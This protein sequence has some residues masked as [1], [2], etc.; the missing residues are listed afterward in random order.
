MASLR[1][2][3]SGAVSGALMGAELGSIIPGLG[4]LLGTGIGGLLGGLGAL[5]GRELPKGVMSGKDAR[6]LLGQGLTVDQI[7][8]LGPVG[9][10][11]PGKSMRQFEKM[12]ISQ[13]DAY[14][15]LASGGQGAGAGKLAKKFPQL[16]ATVGQFG[17]MASGAGPMGVPGFEAMLPA[18]MGNQAAFINPAA[19]QWLSSLFPSAAPTQPAPIPLGV[20]GFGGLPG[21]SG[22]GKP[23]PAPNPFL[24]LNALA[25]PFGNGGGPISPSVPRFG[26]QRNPLR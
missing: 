23:G 25:G 3:A 14:R 21:F 17:G 26:V 9:S 7:L 20:P 18:I 12:G 4:T 15:L 2:P 5:G 24:G 10:F 22:G 6:K 1:G 11:H 13:E 8:S 16:A 19:S